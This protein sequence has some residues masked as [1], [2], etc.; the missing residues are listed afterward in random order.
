MFLF[1]LV[2]NFSQAAYTSYAIPTQIEYVSNGILVSGNFGDPNGCGK[3]NY[4]F[5]PID[6]ANEVAYQSIL[7]MVLTG[8]TAQREMKFHTNSCTSVSFHWN[9]Q[10]I[11]ETSSG[12]AVFIR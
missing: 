5:I 12:N 7:S 2:A 9:G 4:V 1:S 3:S 10:V 11:N 6:P 8:F